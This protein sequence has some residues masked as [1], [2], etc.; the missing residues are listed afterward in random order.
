V[1]LPQVAPRPWL[2]EARCEIQ[3]ALAEADWFEMSG[4]KG[5]EPF[6]HV[7]R[8]ELA[9]LTGDE[10]TRERELL[11]AHRLFVEERG[12]ELLSSRHRDRTATTSEVVGAPRGDELANAPRP[13]PRPLFA[14]SA[15]RRIQ[16][17]ESSVTLAAIE[18]ATSRTALSRK[19][20]APTLRS[21]SPK[22][23][24]NRS[25]RSRESASR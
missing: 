16:R 22:R 24:C 20:A 12:G 23:S 8:A 6:L 5:Y 14:G 15:A 17:G 1:T 3:V 10:A 11:E 13:S 2:D 4:A 25:P 18:S 7:E 19:I 21:T 9:K